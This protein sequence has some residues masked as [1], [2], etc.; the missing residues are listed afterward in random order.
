M[1]IQ[2]F[3]SYHYGYAAAISVTILLISSVFAFIY[4]RTIAGESLHAES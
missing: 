3:L 2:G 1:Y 4:L